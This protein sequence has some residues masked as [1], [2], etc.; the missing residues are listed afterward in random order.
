MA[1]DRRAGLHATIAVTDRPAVH[2]ERGGQ[3]GIPRVVVALEPDELDLLLLQPRNELAHVAIGPTTR[4]RRFDQVAR[5][6]ESPDRRSPAQALQLA[7]GLIECVGRD[8]VAAR[9]A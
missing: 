9:G 8:D 2:L 1:D 5:N 4:A 7:Q 3:G 6:D